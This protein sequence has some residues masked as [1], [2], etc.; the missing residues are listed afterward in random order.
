MNPIRSIMAYENSILCYVLVLGLPCS[1]LNSIQMM[2]KQGNVQN[3]VFSQN[4]FT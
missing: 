4:C 2:K 3:V 1:A